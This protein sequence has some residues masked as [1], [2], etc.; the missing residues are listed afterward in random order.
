[1]NIGIYRLVF[2]TSRG[3]W[4]AVSE[5]VRSHQNGK[6]SSKTSGSKQSKQRATLYI[7]LL[8]INVVST[9]NIAFAEAI[10]PVNTIPTGLQVTSGNI[11]IQAPVFFVDRKK[12]NW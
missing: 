7:L 1:M 8:G 2:N 6:N 11:T 3:I 9:V 5:H 4:M 12:E 10:L